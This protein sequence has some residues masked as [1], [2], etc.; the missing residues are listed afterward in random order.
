MLNVVFH[1]AL[2]LRGQSWLAPHFLNV[3]RLLA[4]KWF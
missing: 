4:N 2:S 1:T 3:F